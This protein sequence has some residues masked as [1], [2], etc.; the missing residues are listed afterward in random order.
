M[1][2][3]GSAPVVRPAHRLAVLAAVVVA[4]TGWVLVPQRGAEARAP[5]PCGE[6]RRRAGTASGRWSVSTIALTAL[7]V[8]LSTA[9]PGRAV[10]V[11]PVPALG[12]DDLY[13]WPARTVER[14]QVEPGQC[15]GTDRP[16]WDHLF[17]VTEGTTGSLRVAID[18]RLAR[19][20]VRD[21]PDPAHA[22]DPVASPGS[23]FHVQV[24]GPDGTSRAEAKKK[25]PYSQEVWLPGPV[26]PGRWRVR[27]TPVDV[28]RRVF[29]VRAAI[30]VLEPHG[31]DGMP[32]NPNLRA[33]APFELTFHVPS[34]NYGPGVPHHSSTGACMVEETVEDV[35]DLGSRSARTDCLRF[36]FGMENVGRGPLLIASP[37]RETPSFESCDGY[38][39]ERAVQRRYATDRSAGRPYRGCCLAS[40][41][42]VL[43]FDPSHLHTHYEEAWSAELF[44][45]ATEGWRP[46]DREPILE[47]VATAPKSG[48]NPGN[49]VM[50]Q[51][52][53][54]AQ[55]DVGWR[56][57]P[58]SA[59][60]FLPAGWGD[61]YEWNR[62]GNGIPLPESM[63]RG[64]YLL[65][66]TV[67]PQG[68][69]IESDES[70]NESYA[71]FEV[72]G[73]RFARTISVSQR[74]LGRSPWSAPKRV[75]TTIP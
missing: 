1:V 49:E 22:G 13:V 6:R 70:D 25:R 10:G 16:C 43:R 35:V 61:I 4:A 71:L 69:L 20:F 19:D 42:G 40:D 66:V 9:V 48:F 59:V 55:D 24:F 65:R 26:A 62:S 75:S 18:A 29:R 38:P 73:D 72:S 17:D 30:D 12:D 74:G 63:E 5:G 54:L 3:N 39:N 51:F 14:A 11:E 23:T 31:A 34:T 47:P 27:V 60:E 53:R 36:S 46:G 32:L 33:V 2:N 57:P 37:C 58:N 7:L 15:D 67:D 56:P 28:D 8:A 45:V 50:A 52:D 68:W 44:R 21:W 64:W 41:A